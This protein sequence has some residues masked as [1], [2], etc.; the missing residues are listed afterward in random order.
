MAK[1]KKYR[2]VE[3]GKLENEELVKTYKNHSVI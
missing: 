1:R 3:N 2:N